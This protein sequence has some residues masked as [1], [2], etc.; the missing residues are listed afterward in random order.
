MT[1][2]KATTTHKVTNKLNIE[3]RCQKVLDLLDLS[4]AESLGLELSDLPWTLLL[5]GMVILI[6]NFFFFQTRKE[7][8]GFYGIIQIFPEDLSKPH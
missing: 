8:S 7:N 4:F 3:S 1:I 5:L 2:E 6:T